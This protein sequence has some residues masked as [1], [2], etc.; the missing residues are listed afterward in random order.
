MACQ[1]GPNSWESSCDTIWPF[2]SFGWTRV[3]KK[4]WVSVAECLQEVGWIRDPECEGKHTLAMLISC[5]FSLEMFGVDFSFD[6]NTIAFHAFLI[7]APCSYSAK[8]QKCFHQWNWGKNQTDF[9][10]KNA[11]P[12][13]G[14]ML[15]G[16]NPSPEA[17]CFASTPLWSEGS[18]VLVCQVRCNKD[19]KAF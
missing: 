4:R 8:K 16:I 7:M 9:L 10:I 12:S 2:I 13:S 3:T 1:L 6:T 17:N 15:Q 14:C 18:G 11:S 5:A 19:L